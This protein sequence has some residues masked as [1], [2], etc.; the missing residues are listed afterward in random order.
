MHAIRKAI[1]QDL[2]RLTEIYNHAI[3]AGYCTSDMDLFSNEERIPWFKEHLN[4]RFPIFVYEKE[5]RVLG[6]SYI[7]PYRRGRK[8]LSKVCEISYYIDMEHRR[9][10]IGSLLM[11]HT[12]DKAR[13]IGFTTAIAVS[14]SCND[15]SIGLLNKYGFQKWGMLPDAA[16]LKCGVHS[17]LY[18]GI[19][20]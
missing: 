10:G 12:I 16:E 6:Y 8:A 18:Y 3:D 19:K 7:S 2:K 14:L 17:Q 11:E 5:G 9:Q 15:A 20:L 13:E 1:E 4:Y